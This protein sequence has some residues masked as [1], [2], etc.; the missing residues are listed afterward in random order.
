ML[1]NRFYSFEGFN[2]KTFPFLRQPAAD[3][4]L[5][6]GFKSFRG[7]D[8]DQKAVEAAK[9]NLSFI[10][11][12]EL[13]KDDLFSSLVI[14]QEFKFEYPKILGLN[15]AGSKNF[16]INQIYQKGGIA[17]G[18]LFFLVLLIKLQ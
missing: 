6:F 4:D 17:L 8:I 13:S 7:S 15:K 18:C 2:K 9:Q 5:G 12:A 14:Q 11:E 1:L 16:Y 10:K 3:L